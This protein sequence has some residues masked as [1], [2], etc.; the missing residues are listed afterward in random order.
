MCNKTNREQ[1]TGSLST[2]MTQ[3]NVV[4]LCRLGCKLWTRA[5]F[6][7]IGG[8]ILAQYQDSQKTGEVF[9]YKILPDI[10]LAQANN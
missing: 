6:T 2:W 1:L 5:K 3:N 9:P 10:L 8:L 4:R 7:M